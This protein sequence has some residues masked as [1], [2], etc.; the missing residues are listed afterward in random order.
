MKFL[1]ESIHKFNPG[2]FTIRIW[3]QEATSEYI[4]H[5]PTIDFKS[6]KNFLKTELHHI[7]LMHPTVQKDQQHFAELL[8]QITGVNAVEVIDFYGTGVVLYNDW[9]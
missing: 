8:L 2:L 3:Y 4:D 5:L 9:P 6:T 7:W 1:A